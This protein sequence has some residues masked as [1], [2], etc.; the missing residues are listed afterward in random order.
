MAKVLGES[1]RYVSNQAVAKR[2]KILLLGI[3]LIAFASMVE[4]VVLGRW[5]L[6]AKLSSATT[7][8]IM[9]AFLLVMLIVFWL[10]GKKIDELEKGCAAMQRGAAG[11]IG[12][13]SI[14]Q[15]FPDN[16]YVIN[17]LTTPFGNLDHV[18]VGPTGVFVI[19]T[20]NWRGVVS[21]DGKGELLLNGNL[22]DKP[23][24]RQFVARMMGIRDKVVG[25]IG[26]GH[27]VFYDALFVF[28]SARVE[29]NWGRTSSV[30]CIMDDQL[31]GYIV[32]KDFGRKLEP[33]EAERIAQAF[34]AVARMDKDFGPVSSVTP[35]AN[36]TVRHKTSRIAK[37]ASE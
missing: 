15:K 25:L 1:G 18:V 27:E 5:L 14:L 12:V 7:V 9:F 37:A 29:A 2:Q 35:S 11:E 31:W 30:N 17:D 13:G 21:T 4:G 33:R 19:D 22:T 10:V 36:E 28:T 16:F 23:F 24:V 26:S 3:L 20:K 6:P 8:V 34:L 32:E